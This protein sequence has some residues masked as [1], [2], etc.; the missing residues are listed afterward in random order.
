LFNFIKNHKITLIYVS[1]VIYWLILFTLTSLP[2]TKLPETHINDK[3]EHY[4]AFCILSV[5]LTFTFQLQKKYSS[6]HRYSYLFSILFV[7]LYGMLD[8]LH[9]LYVPGRYCDI[10]DWIADVSGGIFGLIIV[11]IINKLSKRISF[12]Q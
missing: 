6:L 8:E 5:L 7:A 1:L 2:S 9:Q 4:A 11:F 12:N 10:N 3:V